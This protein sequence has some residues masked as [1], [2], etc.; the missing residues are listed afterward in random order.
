MPNPLWSWAITAAG[1]TFL[2]LISTGRAWPWLLSAIGQIGWITY[3]A[4][5]RQWGFVLMGCANA[6]VNLLG[7]RRVRRR[8]A[9]AEVVTS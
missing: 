6:V 7:W 5:T 9:E 1:L 4:T 2:Y 3:G 8:L